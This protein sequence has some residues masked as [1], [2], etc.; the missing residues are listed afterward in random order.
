MHFIAVFE[1]HD[2]VF[3]VNLKVMTSNFHSEKLDYYILPLYQFE[4]PR[5]SGFGINAFIA[6]FR[7]HDLIFKVNFKVMTSNFQ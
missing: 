6:F 3:K 2:L 1:G 5:L 7:G 4:H